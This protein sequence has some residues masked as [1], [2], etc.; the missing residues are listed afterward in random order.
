V[1]SNGLPNHC[2]NSPTNNLA[3]LT[4]DFEVRFNWKLPEN[5]TQNSVATQDEVNQ[6]ICST[7]STANSNIPT[8]ANFTSTSLTD[9]T[10]IVGIAFT[11][12]AIS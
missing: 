11:G 2:Y 9:L 6:L 12:V 5:F 10:T 1:Q 7:Q 3:N 4:I 8:K